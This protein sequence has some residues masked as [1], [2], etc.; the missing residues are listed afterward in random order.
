MI[1]I[2]LLTLILILIRELLP[3]FNGLYNKITNNFTVRKVSD[4]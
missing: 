4:L 1:G 3:A 2:F